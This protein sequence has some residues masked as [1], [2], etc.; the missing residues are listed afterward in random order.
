MWSAKSL[1]YF[2]VQTPEISIRQTCG[3]WQFLEFGAS[4]IQPN[5]CFLLWDSPSSNCISQ[6]QQE[7]VPGMKRFSKLFEEKQFLKPEHLDSC[8]QGA[9]FGAVNLLPPHGDLSDWNLHNLRKLNI[10]NT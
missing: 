7:N 9:E 2:H 5:S 6:P 8:Q 3:S 1:E 4:D 10:E